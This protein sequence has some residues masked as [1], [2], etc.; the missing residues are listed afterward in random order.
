MPVI[1][2]NK[3]Y[4]KPKEVAEK[5]GEPQHVIRYWT[6]SFPDIHPEVHDSF[7][8]LYSEDDLQRLTLIK[9]LLRQELLRIDEAKE[10]YDALR[11]SGEL[12][13]AALPQASTEQSCAVKAMESAEQDA[14]GVPNVPV[15]SENDDLGHEVSSYHSH[16]E[17]DI[18]VTASESP[19]VTGIL[20]EA[21]EPPT[22]AVTIRSYPL[23]VSDDLKAQYDACL[24]DLRARSQELAYY[25]TSYLVSQKK[26][27]E[28]EELLGDTQRKLSEMERT[29]K[30]HA[31]E[32]LASNIK[33]EAKDAAIAT[34]E[35]QVTALD[36]SL[37]NV[38]AEFETAHQT[39]MRLQTE[40]REAQQKLTSSQASYQEM[41]TELVMLRTEQ[42]KLKANLLQSNFLKK[43]I[44]LPI[45]RSPELQINNLVFATSSQLVP[46]LGTS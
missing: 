3:Q 19:I 45:S 41:M 26:L 42:T 39:M 29:E 6:K 16:S 24:Q 37:R 25:R 28:C 13:T 35:T 12:G 34:L 15:F 38:R 2:E 8:R 18:E 22:H 23:V 46:K 17:K 40:L 7:V 36:T 5:L 14:V 43:V 20:D 27:N 4:F 10:R 1:I 11:K 9:K 44:K 21:D 33:M 30:L 31:A 32:L